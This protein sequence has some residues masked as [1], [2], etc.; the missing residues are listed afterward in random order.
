M[1][2]S[3]QELVERLLAPD[4]QSIEAW[5]A[6]GLTLAEISY[7]LRDHYQIQI[8]IETVRRWLATKAA[9]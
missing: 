8:S 6:D 3:T 2:S 1:A 5:R 9:A 7:R 4:G